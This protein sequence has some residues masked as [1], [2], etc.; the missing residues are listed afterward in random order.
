MTIGIDIDE[1]LRALL[2]EMVR[3]YNEE[4]N[5]SLTVDDVKAF[6]VDISFPKVK[7]RTGESASKWF[8][9]EHGRELFYDSQMIKG[10][11]EA[12]DH[13]RKFAKV[14]IISYQ[15]T[16]QNKLDT[17][18]WLLKNDIEYDGICFLKD[19][20][21]VHLDVLID[22]NDWNFIGCNSKAGV[23]VT[24]PYNKDVDMSELK[25]KSNCE[26]IVRFGSLREFVSSY[27]SCHAL[28]MAFS[29]IK[30]DTREI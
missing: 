7:E 29:Q 25:A 17:L 11:K 23:L 24:A 10:A 21:L 6:D 5:E 8:F 12:V 20:T 14:Y 27:V 26:E 13:L 22:D 2:P 19:K 1:V 15:K 16:L 30:G 3:L 9:Q 28:V 18:N 4:F